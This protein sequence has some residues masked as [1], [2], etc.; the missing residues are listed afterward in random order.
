MGSFAAF[1][2]HQKVK[3]HKQWKEGTIKFNSQGNKVLL[4]DENGTEIDRFPSNLSLGFDPTYLLDCSVFFSGK[5]Q[6]GLELEMERNLVEVQEAHQAEEPLSHQRSFSKAPAPQ[7]PPSSST[8]LPSASSASSASSPSPFGNSY[9]HPPLGNRRIGLRAP[10]NL[11]AEPKPFISP[12]SFPR[13]LSP[14]HDAQ[15]SSLDKEP[16]NGLFLLFLR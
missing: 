2:T 15:E 7:L 1:Y 12:P 14:T 5:L 9:P 8:S 16:R 10:R 11:P 13:A 4:L 6:E 3:K